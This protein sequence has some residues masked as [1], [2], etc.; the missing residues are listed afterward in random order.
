[1]IYSSKKGSKTEKHG[2]ASE[3]ATKLEPHH[4]RSDL[5]IASRFNYAKIYTIEHNVKVLFIGQVNQRNMEILLSGDTGWMRSDTGEDIPVVMEEQPCPCS[6]CHGNRFQFP[7]RCA[8]PNG[9][10]PSVALP[11]GLLM[12]SSF[13]WLSHRMELYESSATLGNVRGSFQL[14]YA[15]QLT[16]ADYEPSETRD[17][18]KYPRSHVGRSKRNCLRLLPRRD[19]RTHWSYLRERNTLQYFGKHVRTS[20]CAGTRRTHRVGDGGVQHGRDRPCLPSNYHRLLNSL[21]LR[22]WTQTSCT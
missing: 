14:C 19:S 18:Q 17:P 16:I 20:T 3:Q 21:Q 15:P 8:V 4:V 10:I 2:G 9:M 1:M 5:D 22:G 13:L 6:D 7:C 12:S 11:S